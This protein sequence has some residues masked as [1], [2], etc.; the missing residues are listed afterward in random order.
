M[1]VRPHFAVLTPKAGLR[2]AGVRCND[3][4]MVGVCLGIQL[5]QNSLKDTN[6]GSLPTA[7]AKTTLGFWMCWVPSKWM[8]SFGCVGVVFRSW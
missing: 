3:S 2:P 4:C 1:R 5:R 6:A 7:P 8:G